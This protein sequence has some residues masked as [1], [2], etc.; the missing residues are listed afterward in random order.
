MGV[1]AGDSVFSMGIVPVYW[2]VVKL[3]CDVVAGVEE[4][5]RE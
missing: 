2:T 4:L 3:R 1:A 5:G